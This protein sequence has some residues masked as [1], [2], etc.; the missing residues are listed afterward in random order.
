MTPDNNKKSSNANSP[1]SSSSVNNKE[2]ILS[3]S[4]LQKRINE[5]RK[6]CLEARAELRSIRNSLKRI[7]IKLDQMKQSK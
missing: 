5:N 1:A 7:E 6:Q 4:Q 2:T 3:N